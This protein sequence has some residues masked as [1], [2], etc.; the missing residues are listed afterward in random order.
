MDPGVTVMFDCSQPAGPRCQCVIYRSILIIYFLHLRLHLLDLL[1]R[2]R[3]EL[4]DD[5]PLAR[6]ITHRV[7]RK[8]IVR[9]A[10][11]RGCSK[12][13]CGAET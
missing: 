11:H 13:H 2:D 9:G 7:P 3:P 12:F 5:A 6:L 8:R 4:L 10:R 1:R